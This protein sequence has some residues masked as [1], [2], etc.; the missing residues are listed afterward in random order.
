MH[1]YQSSKRMCI[2][3]LCN[4][5]SIRRKAKPIY[6]A[7]IHSTLNPHISISSF[8]PDWLEKIF[9]DIRLEFGRHCEEVK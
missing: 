7:L 5:Y 2:I 4:L 9:F 6:S 3:P 8:T 1:H